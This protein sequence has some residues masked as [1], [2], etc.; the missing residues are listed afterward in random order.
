MTGMKKDN[1]T[2]LANG[3]LTVGLDLGDKY[4]QVCVIED[5]AEV[6]EEARIRTTADALRRKFEAME[7]CLIAF[8]AGTHSPWVSRLIESL[9]HECLVANPAA[10]HRKGR[11]KNDKVDAEKLARWARSDPEMLN[12]ITHR[13]EDMQSDMTLIY[14][15]RCLVEARTKL[16][17]TARGLVKAYGGRLP[18]CDARSFPDR[19]KDFVP[20]ALRPAIDPLLKM[21]AGLSEEIHAV[22]KKVD[23]LADEKYGRETGAMRQIGGVGPLISTA[24]VLVIRDPYRFKKSRHVGPYLGLTRRQDKSGES[25][26][27]LHISKAGNEYLRQLLVGGAHYILGPFGPDCDLRHW[28]LRKAQA[29]KNA[30]K[31]AVVAVA[32]KLAVLMHRLWLTGEVYEPLRG[33]EVVTSSTEQAC[34]PARESSCSSR[35]ARSASASARFQTLTS[36]LN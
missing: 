10:L 2:S 8:E 32:R 35:S 12:P 13:S 6:L 16:I 4:S 14:S 24:F 27:E 3:G 31:R 7:P 29:G 18:A 33:Q 19:V 11:K 21:I 36:P 34:L 22:D 17:N 9:G 15:R 20:E 5:T 30:K 1:T 26:P 28:G 23:E 25:D